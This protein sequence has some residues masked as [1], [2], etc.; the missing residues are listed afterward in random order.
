MQS[1]AMQIEILKVL[2]QMQQAMLSPPTEQQQPGGWSQG[3]QPNCKTP[4]NHPFPRRKT[5]KY[6]WTHGECSHELLA[7]NAKKPGHQDIASFENCKGGSNAHCSPWCGDQAECINSLVSMC[8][9]NSACSSPTIL[10]KS[11]P[12]G[13]VWRATIIFLWQTSMSCCKLNNN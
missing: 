5:N 3:D 2:Q 13:A 8:C 7:R 11:L 9:I 10:T 4:D 1:S 6:C 12:K